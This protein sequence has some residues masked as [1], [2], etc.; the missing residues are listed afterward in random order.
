MVWIPESCIWVNMHPCLQVARLHMA[1]W[2]I[3]GDST[4][5]DRGAAVLEHGPETTVHVQRQSQCFLNA[6]IITHSW[7]TQLEQSISQ[8][9][10]SSNLLAV[11]M[12]KK[13]S[14]Q[15]GRYLVYNIFE[16]QE[17]GVK[18]QTVR[19]EKDWY[20]QEK[21]PVNWWPPVQVLGS[22]DVPT[23]HAFCSSSGTER[24]QQQVE[25]GTS[26][27]LCMVAS[28]ESPQHWKTGTTKAHPPL[29]YRKGCLRQPSLSSPE[30]WHRIPEIDFWS[31]ILW[32]IHFLFVDY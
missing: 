15:N 2:H 8:N 1:A 24:T 18:R 3:C 13:I 6:D 16:K 30:G 12:S 23:H 17:T 7:Q 29:A 28:Q 4:W 31:E 5:Q 32:E 19:E 14:S 22:Q 21:V 11:S 9:L 26:L 20:P 25:T 27:H 10:M